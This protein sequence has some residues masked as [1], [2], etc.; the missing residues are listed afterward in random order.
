MIQQLKCFS[1]LLTIRI[2]IPVRRA[3]LL[4][5]AKHRAA[6]LS[7]KVSTIRTGIRRINMHTDAEPKTTSF[8]VIDEYQ[9]LNEEELRA[10]ADTRRLPYAVALANITGDLNTG[11]IIRSACVS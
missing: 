6:D 10:I 2:I 8:N 9:H 5:K 4:R 11:T 3:A 1:G 7:S